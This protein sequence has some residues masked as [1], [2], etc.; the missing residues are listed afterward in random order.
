MRSG[1]RDADGAGTP[2]AVKIVVT[3][4]PGVGKT[5]LVGTV[6]ELRTLRMEDPST[7]VP[8]GTTV[9]FGRIAVRRGLT[10]CLFGASMSGGAEELGNELCARALGVV[11]LADVRRL[12]DSFAAVDHVEGRLPFVVAVN[13]FPGVERHAPL[14]IARALDLV[15][16]TPVLLCDVRDRDS[17]K[18]VLIRL[19]EHAARWWEQAPY[20][21]T[22]V[23]AG[24][25]V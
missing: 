23:T 1:R 22:D 16:G 3:G 10:A 6:G 12:G 15:D 25:G 2:G 20:A 11:V 17:G 4:G 5:T 18:E 9:D 7:G 8:A 13:C 21:V 19:V 14:D 24:T